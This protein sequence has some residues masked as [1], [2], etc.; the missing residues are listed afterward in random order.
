MSRRQT[1]RVVMVYQRGFCSRCG[2]P[3][4][5]NEKLK[6][7]TAHVACPTDRPAAEVA[8]GLSA[9]E[10]GIPQAAGSGTW[11]AKD[12]GESLGSPPAEEAVERAPSMSWSPP[13]ATANVQRSGLST[14]RSRYVG[15]STVATFFYWTAWIVGILGTLGALASLGV[16]YCTQ[17]F[18][19]EESCSGADTAKVVTFFSVL[20]GAWFTA[21][22]L[23]WMSYTLRLL[24]DV[25][26]RI[27]GD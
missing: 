7:L 3:L 12:E 26:A 16:D 21:C 13:P 4:G 27:R 14:G 15:A 23:F 2:Q 17:G 5:V 11:N 22:L 1:R 10:E 20:I 19:G 8:A 24:S 18:F 9:R 6:G 25:E